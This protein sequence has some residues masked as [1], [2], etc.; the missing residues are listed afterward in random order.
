M[1]NAGLILLRTA[2]WQV[3]IHWSNVDSVPWSRKQLPTAL[4]EHCTQVHSVVL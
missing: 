4:T 2:T 3:L 1:Y